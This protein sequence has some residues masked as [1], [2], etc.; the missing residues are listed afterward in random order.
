VS[1]D[2]IRINLDLDVKDF[3]IGVDA[4]GNRLATL[5]AAAQK[6]GN[7]I[8]KVQRGPF[9]GFLATLRDLT[10]GFYA[11]QRVATT[12]FRAL[13]GIAAINGEFERTQTLLAGMS[14]EV[15]SFQ[16]QLAAG[17]EFEHFLNLATEAPFSLQAITNSAVKLKSAGIDPLAGGFDSLIDSV[18]SFGG[19]GDQLQRASIAIQQMSGKGVV[20]MEELRQQLG[21]AVPSAMFLMARSMGLAMDEFTELVTTGAVESQAAI[22]GMTQEME[23][24]FGGAAQRMT[25]TWVG[26]TQRLQTEWQKFIKNVGDNGSFDQMKDSVESLIAAMQ[27]D[28]GI[29]LAQVIND[30]VAGIIRFSEKVVTMTLE[31]L[32][33]FFN[34]MQKLSDLHSGKFAD[35]LETVTDIISTLVGWYEELRNVMTSLMESMK[36][37]LSLFDGLRDRLELINESV[38]STSFGKWA[39]ELK[40]LAELTPFGFL[41]T[42]IE[43]NEELGEAFNLTSVSARRALEVMERG[44]KLTAAQI[45]AATGELQSQLAA[46][47]QANSEIYEVGVTVDLQGVEGTIAQIEEIKSKIATLG[48]LAEER[49]QQQA[50]TANR[51]LRR[52]FQDRLDTIN[53]GYRKQAEAMDDA[54]EITGDE[55]AQAATYKRLIIART[56]AV[57]ALI[58]DQI[59]QATKSRD[60]LLTLQQSGDEAAA[61]RVRIANAQI[62]QLNDERVEL[63]EQLEAS[64]E[65]QARRSVVREAAE[66]KSLTSQIET[67]VESIE[68]NAAKAQGDFEGASGAAAR[69]RYELEEG[70]WKGAFDFDIDL[71]TLISRV[72]VADARIKQLA[73]ATKLRTAATR[74]ATSAENLLITKTEALAQAQAALN[75]ELSLTSDSTRTLNARLAKLLETYSRAPEDMAAFQEKLQ[76]IRDVA[77]ETDALNYFGDMKADLAELKNSSLPEAERLYA[78]YRDTILDIAGKSSQALQSLSEE[79]AQA[80]KEVQ[81]ETVEAI[82]ADYQKSMDDLRKDNLSSWA[83]TTDE[84]QGMTESWGDD[85]ID[86]LLDGETSFSDFA[87][88]I[89]K[90]I[91]KIMIKW[92]MLKALGINTGGGVE[93]FLDGLAGSIGGGL[94]GS[95]SA[96]LTTT[97]PADAPV[98][99]TSPTVNNNAPLFNKIDLSVSNDTAAFDSALANVRSFSKELKGSVASSDALFASTAQLANSVVKAPISATASV[100]LPD[101]SRFLSGIN[102][103]LTAASPTLPDTE[104]FMAA[105]SAAKGF[106]VDLPETAALRTDV[107]AAFDQ[108]SL[109]LPDASALRATMAAAFKQPS[110]DLPDA[111]ALRNDVTAAFSQSAIELPDTTALAADVAA[112]AKTSFPA[113][114]E[115]TG[116]EGEVV[117]PDTEEF[118]TNMNAA[119]DQQLTLPDTESFQ[120][121]MRAAFGHQVKLPETDVFRADLD[122]AFNQQVKLPDAGPFAASLVTAFDQPAIQLPNSAQFSADL[123]AAFAQPAMQLPDSGTFAE[124]IGIAFDTPVP[125]LPD[126]QSL[127]GDMNDAFAQPEVALPDSTRAVRD[128]NTALSNLNFSPDTGD[129]VDRIRGAQV[130]DLPDTQGFVNSFR[131]TLRSAT[132]ELPDTSSFASNLGNSGDALAIGAERAISQMQEG[133]NGAALPDIANWAGEFGDAFAISLPDASALTDQLGAATIGIEQVQVAELGNSITQAA[134]AMSQAQTQVA[135]PDFDEMYRAIESFSSVP[136]DVALNQQSALATDSLLSVPVADVVGINDT[137]AV[138]DAQTAGTS[139]QGGDDTQGRNA[140]APTVNLMNKS[141][142]NLEPTSSSFDA[143]SQVLDIVLSAASRPGSFR[144]G[145]RQAVR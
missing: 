40:S 104:N 93:S 131:E 132:F 110:V 87:A 1:V 121:N 118:V 60:R 73:E 79:D 8:A 21:E 120:S 44:G 27:S 119:F 124:N 88:S 96:G 91:A 139:R 103:G 90:D 137:P 98:A 125:A 111:S 26:V 23:R 70:R 95:A 84:L 36:G 28:E 48:V 76:G 55:D 108:P 128:A 82:T 100:D 54:L 78:E 9:R 80:F 47:R 58:D 2:S 81:A 116:P 68:R 85:F 130:A 19:S 43:E 115:M 41:M 123:S 102:N 3:N 89:L 45:T 105:F 144:T 20:S 31:Y 42:A 86:M 18:A 66:A 71:D 106:S 67:Y 50:S 72:E 24:S 6:A 15:D 140:P 101:T 7:Q 135:T 25:T 11:V 127:V 61:D 136:P 113:A 74:A 75:P 145:I 69:L 129:F 122:A 117:L 38:S 33:R 99:T 30:V 126:A 92:A 114:P 37:K 35:G 46:L 63:G 16:R 65:Q 133:I 57:G 13:N 141:G 53:A 77:A 107:D 49:L 17:E 52:D 138:S 4:A 112:F 32:P 12:A 5:G 62:K 39:A 51:I 83:T 109:G 14:T 56:E 97:T 142:Q 10:V 29:L 34:V 143:S 94:A 59:A 64:L 134:E 22:L